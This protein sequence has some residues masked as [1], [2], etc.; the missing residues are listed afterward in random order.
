VSLAEKVGEEELIV[1][2]S[3]RRSPGKRNG[4]N[5]VGEVSLESRHGERLTDA[6]WGVTGRLDGDDRE[7]IGHTDEKEINNKKTNMN[8]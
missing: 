4:E 1:D 5:I 3:A 2:R 6:T 7:E 8:E